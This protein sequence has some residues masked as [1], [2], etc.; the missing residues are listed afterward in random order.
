[1]NVIPFRY[2]VLLLMVTAVIPSE[3]LAQSKRFCT[4]KD[5]IHT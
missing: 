2:A 1:M 5:R 3:V 4:S